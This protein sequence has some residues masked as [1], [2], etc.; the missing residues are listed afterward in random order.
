MK[1]RRAGVAF[2][3]C[4]LLGILALF[5]LDGI[6][7]GV[8]ALVTIL[9]FIFACIIALGRQDPDTD[10]PGVGGWVGHWF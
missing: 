5:V 2:A 10:R 4:A 9:A 8:A 3:L 6:A 7:A 1:R